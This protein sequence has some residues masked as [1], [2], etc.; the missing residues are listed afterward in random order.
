MQLKNAV[1]RIGAGGRASQILSRMTIGSL[2]GI[3]LTTV[4]LS[5]QAVAQETE[6]VKKETY[7]NQEVVASQ[8]LIKFRERLSSERQFLLEYLADADRFQEIGGAG[9]FLLRSRSK[10][11]ADLLETAN[12]FEEVEAS[13]PDYIFKLVRLPNDP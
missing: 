12:S 10:K 7:Q 3:L 9:W 11:V 8:I 4:L 5:G 6:S 1:E 2:F 13:E